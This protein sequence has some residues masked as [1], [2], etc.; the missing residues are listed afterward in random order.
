MSFLGARGPAV[1]AGSTLALCGCMGARV[2]QALGAPAAAGRLCHVERACSAHVRNTAVWSRPRAV[3][4]RTIGD[5]PG[6]RSVSAL[7]VYLCTIAYSPD[8]LTSTVGVSLSV[9]STAICLT[10][11]H[12]RVYTVHT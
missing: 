1:A 2:A 5:T 12:G 6:S 7:C 8:P 10:M 3:M 11:T 4:C 9:Y